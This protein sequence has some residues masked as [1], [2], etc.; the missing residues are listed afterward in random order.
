MSGTLFASLFKKKNNELDE[1]KKVKFDGI[2]AIW[3]KTD[4]IVLPYRDKKKCCES[5]NE[6]FQQINACY[7][8]IN[9]KSMKYNKI[10]KKLINCINFRYILYDYDCLCT[11]DT[12]HR[13]VKNYYASFYPQRK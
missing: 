11:H 12:H 8:P 3:H 5:I 10:K 6:L 13:S 9:K 7:D 2:A 1:K 4:C